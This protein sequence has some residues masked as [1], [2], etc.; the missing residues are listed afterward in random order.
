MQVDTNDI[1]GVT[2]IMCD[3][4]WFNQLV[5]YLYHIPLKYTE[6]KQK[7]KTSIR[8]KRKYSSITT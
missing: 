5:A 2:K 3:P 4:M 1:M 8:I 6:M 7:V